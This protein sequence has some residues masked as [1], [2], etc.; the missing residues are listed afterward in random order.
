VQLVLVRRRCQDTGFDSPCCLSSNKLNPLSTVPVLIQMNPVVRN[1]LASVPRSSSRY[2]C[3]K[4]SNRR[5]PKPSRSFHQT[6][7]SRASEGGAN[8]PEGAIETEDAQNRSEELGA[9][10]NLPDKDS[11]T[12]MS[13]PPVKDLAHYGSAARRSKRSKAHT[14]VTPSVRIPEW[15]IDRNVGTVE[16]I[17]RP[18]IA[19]LRWDAERAEYVDPPDES[20]SIPDDPPGVEPLGDGG[21]TQISEDMRLP[22]KARYYVDSF[23]W[24]ELISTSR[25]LL[26]PKTQFV[27]DDVASR[28]NHLILHYAGEGGDF[29]LD[30]LIQKLAVELRADTIVL[31]AQDITDLAS[32]PHNSSL[33]EDAADDRRLL[34]YDVYQKDETQTNESRREDEQVKESDEQ[35]EEEDHSASN[36]PNIPTVFLDVRGSALDLSNSG[37]PRG[38]RSNRQAGAPPPFLSNLSSLFSGKVNNDQDPVKIAQ[39]RLMPLIEALLAGPLLKRTLRKDASADVK[40]NEPAPTLPIVQA[41]AP[42]ILEIR[43]INVLQQTSFGQRFLNVVY[44]QVQTKRGRGQKIMIVGTDSFPKAEQYSAE[45]IRN[46]Q[47]GSPANISRTMVITPVVPSK[48]AGLILR[49]DKKR[50]TWRINKRHLRQMLCIKVPEDKDNHLRASLSAPFSRKTLYALELLNAERQ[51]WTFDQVHRLATMIAGQMESSAMVSIEDAVNQACM[52]LKGSDNAKF[53]WTEQQKA[54]R[55]KSKPDIERTETQRLEKIRKKLT[56]W[57]KKLVGGVI[58]PHKI[59][60]TFDQV[61]APVETIDALKTL[62]TL[63]L[64]RP[65]AFKYGVLASDKIP[66]L[67]LYG[68]PGTGKTLLAKAVAKESGATVLE[69]S[70]AELNDMYVGEGEKNVRALFSL[71]KKLTPCVVFIDEADAIFSARGTGQRR[72]SHRD[73]LNQFLREWDGM[74][75]DAGSAFIMVA[76]NRPFDLDDAVLRRLPWRLLVDLPSENDRLEIL[77]IHLRGEV[78][79]EDVSL[80]DI[81]A[82]TPFYSG[83][84]LKNLSVAAALN[85]VQDENEEAKNHTGEDSFEHAAKRTLTAAH[86]S[87]ALE[88]ISASISEDMSSLKEI[89]KFDEQFGDKRGRKKKS[90]KW[91][92]STAAEA[93]KALDTV[94]VRS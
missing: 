85:S 87:R 75:N 9:G 1:L 86:F 10:E 2:P 76:T 78:L 28:K 65:D 55:T 5:F 45:N 64:V 71:A 37:M 66:G 39:Q 62:T 11:C 19:L 92:F 34:S 53:A 31:D 83:S 44:D 13:V 59:A 3:R 40:P 21:S 17:G 26:R 67:L 32:D 72:V 89:K 14:E 68:P 8:K 61:H 33:S 94:K 73:L 91:G 46:L 80:P 63:S 41:E 49:T 90:P 30:E 52:N 84:D 36:R 42:L 35:D 38:R 74:S 23:Q 25:G 81:A 6:P 4:I 20:Q 7:N 48:E 82:K 60:T 56:R 51:I 77:K 50:R 88:D 29:L 70:G 54:S 15:F 57:E 16:D 69:V 24:D 79:A 43:D 18:P 47:S 93:D 22:C 12:A 27:A 58:E